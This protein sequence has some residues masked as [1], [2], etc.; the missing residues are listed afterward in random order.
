MEN[1]ADYTDVVQVPGQRPWVVGDVHV[2][3]VE[4]IRGELSHQ[5]LNPQRHRARL[6]RRGERALR[7][8]AALTVGEHASVV[9]RV[10]EQ[11][12]KS[13]AGYSRISLVHN[14]DQ[15]P[16]QDFERDRVELPH[17]S[18]PSTKAD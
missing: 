2:A 7:Q 13:R 12:G 11:A 4:G 1:G 3:R 10:A 16:P 5:F 18:N 6:S 9:M 8:L 17:Y 15:A 14:R